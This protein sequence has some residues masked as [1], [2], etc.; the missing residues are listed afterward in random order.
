MN[1]RTNDVVDP[2][3]TK[4]GSSSAEF[5]AGAAPGGRATTTAN[6]AWGAGF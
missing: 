2:Q 5:K 6:T 3:T 4:M 1:R